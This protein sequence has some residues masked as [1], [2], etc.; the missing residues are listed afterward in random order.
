MPERLR[1]R[2]EQAMI[3]RWTCGIEISTLARQ[4]T[5]YFPGPLKF[6]TRVKRKEPELIRRRDEIYNISTFLGLGLEV[7]SECDGTITW[8]RRAY[9]DKC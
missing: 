1:V 6:R 2:H 8:C 9:G 5:I 7:T 4:L 3:L